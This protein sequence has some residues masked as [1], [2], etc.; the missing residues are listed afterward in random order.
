M[1]KESNDAKHKSTSNGC[2]CVTVCLSGAHKTFGCS[3][4]LWDGSFRPYGFLVCATCIYSCT[5]KHHIFSEVRL[6]TSHEHHHE[7]H[8][9]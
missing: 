8:H 6:F 4:V 1:D 3:D 9:A 7:H 5:C 2:L